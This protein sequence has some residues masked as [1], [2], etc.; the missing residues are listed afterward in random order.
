MQ[1][2]EWPLIVFTI[3]MQMAVGALL[4]LELA[5]VYVARKSSAAEAD[6]MTDRVLLP[7]IVLVGVALVASLL[8]LG[9]YMNAPKAIN[10]LATSWLSREIAFS[11]GFGL[12]GVIFVAFQWFKWANGKVRGFFGVLAAIAGVGLIYVMSRS[13]ML[14]TQ[15]AWNSLATP[16]SFY[17]TSLLLGSLSLCAALYV[18]YL[19]N[20]RKDPDCA[21]CQA[22]LVRDVMGKLSIAAIVALGVEFVVIPLYLASLGAQGGA[23]AKTVALMTG[24]Y[25]IYFVLRLVLAFLGAGVFGVALFQ[26]SKQAV[27]VGKLGALAWSAFLLVLVAEVF[28]RFL[29]YVTRV[30]IGL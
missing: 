10:N 12:L 6:R 18:N 3:L 4:V 20:K 21:D 25:N 16:V 8:H 27:Q 19:I 13:Y 30:G 14:P 7:L 1:T 23:A 29:F 11:V 17:A 15:P 22:D 5:H 24:E 2:T 9:N 28:G 26:S